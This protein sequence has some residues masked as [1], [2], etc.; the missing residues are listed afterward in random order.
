MPLALLSMFAL[1]FAL[2]AVPATAF[3]TAQQKWV[4]RCAMHE[5]ILYLYDVFILFV[6][7]NVERSITYIF[8]GGH[9][10]I[11]DPL[12]LYSRTSEL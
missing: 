2:L 1:L 4:C 12:M 3:I 5:K 11:G 8:R 9:A 6:N 7:F 10:H